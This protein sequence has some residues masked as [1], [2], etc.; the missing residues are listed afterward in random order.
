MLFFSRFYVELTPGITLKNRHLKS[1]MAARG[2]HEPSAC[3]L[4]QGTH[5]ICIPVKE[6]ND[7]VSDKIYPKSWQGGRITYGLLKALFDVVNNVVS[8]RGGRQ[9]DLLKESLAILDNSVTLPKKVSNL[10]RMLNKSID[11]KSTEVVQVL[12]KNK[13][14]LGKQ[15]EKFGIT[16][17][18]LMSISAKNSCPVTTMLSGYFGYYI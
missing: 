13:S 11:S 10:K 12:Y 4:S 2:T 18:L 6:L 1:K 15:C 16:E 3:D 14:E 9:D 17:G 7:L 5:H 8:E